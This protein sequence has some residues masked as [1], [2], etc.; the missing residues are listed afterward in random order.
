MEEL[1]LKELLL[2]FWKKKVLIITITLF[3][4]IVGTIYSYCYV[5]PVYKATTKLA[6]VQTYV[7]TEEN[8]ASKIVSKSNLTVNTKLLTSSLEI[9][10]SDV[11]LQEVVDSL[12]IENLTVDKIKSSISVQN[13]KETD[14]I[15][16]TVKNK[17]ASIAAQVANKTAEVFS[18]KVS[19]MYNDFGNIYTLEEAKPASSPANINHKKDILIATF[20]GLV[21]SAGVILI[22]TMFNEPSK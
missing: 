17:E 7:E 16:I 15:E 6:L 9:I 13:I 19:Q 5:K 4:I 21:I 1:D 3:C 18:K 22:S 8:K 14:I 10:K 20:L 2:I 12:N 11:V